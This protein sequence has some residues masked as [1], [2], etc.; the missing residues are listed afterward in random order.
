MDEIPVIKAPKHCAICIETFDGQEAFEKHQSQLHRRG[1]IE[2]EYC[3]K[4][5]LRK[6]NL[7][8]HIKS[9][10]LTLKEEAKPEPEDSVSQCTQTQ[11]PKNKKNPENYYIQKRIET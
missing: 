11:C 4:R 5:F 3:Y 6:H 2:C 1:D 10:H 7:A 9:T 8:K